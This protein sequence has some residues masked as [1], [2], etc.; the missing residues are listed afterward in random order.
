MM[1][2]RSHYAADAVFPFFA[3]LIER[4]LS[5]LRRCNLTLMKML[6]TEL[7]NEEFSD[8]REEAWVE[9]I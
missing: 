1:D 9:I 2:G 6:Y 3:A 8:Y 4:R 5:Y 7:S